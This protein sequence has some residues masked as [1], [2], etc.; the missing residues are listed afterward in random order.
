MDMLTWIIWMK[1]EL[2]ECSSL[3]MP[4]ECAVHFWE[5]KNISNEIYLKTFCKIVSAFK[6]FIQYRQKET[7]DLKHIWNDESS[8]KGD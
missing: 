3:K 1:V 5:T 4:L 7:L 6:H 2:S 8:E